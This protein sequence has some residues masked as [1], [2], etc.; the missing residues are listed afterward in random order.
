MVI[1]VKK[2][3][4]SLANQFGLPG[5][6]K[7]RKGFQTKTGSQ[8][9]KKPQPFIVQDAFFHK[10]KKDGFRARSAYK[11]MEIQERYNIIEPDMDICDVGAAPGSFIQYTKR[12]IKDTGK[13]VGIDLKPILKYT[14]NN[15]NTIVHS[16]LDIETLIPKVDEFIGKG[17][18]FDL[19]LSDI[20]A[21]TTGIR[22]LDQQRSVE[23]NEKIIEFSE[24]F[25]K[26]GG[27]LLLKV[28]KGDEF[29]ELTH[30]INKHFERFTEF[31][32]KACRDRS[33]EE[34]VICWGRK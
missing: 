26:K 13:I 4:K 24:T 14:Q 30:I 18:K 16:I 20:G 12:I 19:I 28:F 11:L 22:D 5:A 32:P 17:N 3:K 33:F 7:E 8:K 21:D 6:S 34:F 9:K 27:N 15:I 31:K 25:L 1:K 29:Y 23:L 10:A 2:Q